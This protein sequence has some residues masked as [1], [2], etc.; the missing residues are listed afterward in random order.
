MKKPNLVLITLN[1]CII[2]IYTVLFDTNIYLI[3]YTKIIKPYHLF[4]KKMWILKY[5]KFNC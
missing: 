2:L 3:I 1:M 4:L 5:K